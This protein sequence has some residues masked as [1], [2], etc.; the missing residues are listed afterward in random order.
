MSE[1]IFK[2][3]TF[4]KGIWMWYVCQPKAQQGSTRIKSNQFYFPKIEEEKNKYLWSQIVAYITICS[5]T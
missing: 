1:V 4:K 2:N 5:V 3:L